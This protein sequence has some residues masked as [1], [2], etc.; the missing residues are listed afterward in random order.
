MNK[1]CTK[2]NVSFSLDNFYRD[3]SRYDGLS[4]RCKQCIRSDRKAYQESNRENIKIRRN[5]WENKNRTLVNKN[6][7]RSRTKLRNECLEYYGGKCE[8]CGNPNND[9]LVL[10][11]KNG[12]GTKHRHQIGGGT[13]TLYWIKRNN[14][15]EC[16]RI[17]CHNCNA[18]LGLY[19]YCPHSNA[20]K[21]RSPKRYV[22]LRLECFAYYG[23]KCECGIINPEFLTLDHIDGGG[24]EHRRSVG[25]G[26]RFY[27]WLK[28]HKFPPEYKVICWNCHHLKTWE[29]A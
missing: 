6:K 3:K 2:C 4:N 22:S 27:H 29:V 26:S 1:S 11:H 20:S 28:R 13:S 23:G 7:K 14:F 9:I 17:L 25:G 8:C 18:A 5:I 16:F 24:T 21:P 19:G 10:D 12:G 15:P